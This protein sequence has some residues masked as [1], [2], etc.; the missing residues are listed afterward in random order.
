MALYNIWQ[1]FA[2]YELIHDGCGWPKKSPTCTTNGIPSTEPPVPVAKIR[3]SCLNVAIRSGTSGRDR[4][5]DHAHGKLLT[6]REE[7]EEL[8]AVRRVSAVDPVLHVLKP[9]FQKRKTQA[10]TGARAGSGRYQP[11]TPN[12]KGANSS[13]R[14]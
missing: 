4:G 1:I 9:L 5:L 8:Y 11:R 2:A 12:P 6:T 13:T 14:T 7:V 10:A 3:I